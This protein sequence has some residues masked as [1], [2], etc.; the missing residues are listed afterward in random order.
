M[1]DQRVQNEQVEELRE[2]MRLLQGDRRAN[3]DLLETQKK[4]NAT[5][6][7]VLRDDNK[8]LRARVAHLKRT[9]GDEG[10]EAQI[11][12]MKKDIVH[13]RKQYD[14][15]KG[16]STSSNSKLE[17]LKDEVRACELE[18]RRPTDEDTP[19]TRSIRVLE[20]R[21]DKAM[22]KYNEATSIRKTY[23]QI[24]H[25]LKEERVGF[26]NQLSA[27]E[28]TLAAKQR[29]YEEL[30]LLSGDANHAREIAQIELDR[31][32]SGYEEERY[33]RENELRE[34]HQLVQM[35]RQMAERAEK[36]RLER[37]KIVQD[38]AKGLDTEGEQNM[39]AR[40]MEQGEE[41]KAANEA[42][43]K[44]DI[45][46][47]A[48]RKIKEATGVS[49]VNEVIQKIT[50][51]EGT[52]EN[53]LS[54]TKENAQRMDKLTNEATS[55]KARLDTLKFSGGGGGHRRK[56]VDDQEDQLVTSN[57]RLHR[58]TSKFERLNLVL[59]SSKAGIQHISSKLESIA[60]DFP[61]LKNVN[62]SELV[63]VLQIITRSSE[64]M[65]NRVKAHNIELG[66]LNST[67]SSS[68][69]GSV[70]SL[71]ASSDSSADL[72]DDEKILSK[73][74]PFN[75]R[76]TLPSGDEWEMMHTPGDGENGEGGEADEE[77]LT[78]AKVK[79]ASGQIVLSHSGKKRRKK[80]TAQ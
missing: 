53:L 17:I 1:N 63:E 18:S 49:D 38:N 9:E 11:V 57:A 52:T 2:R 79:E 28:R 50:S 26:D 65:M 25:R 77:E 30:L 70:P 15:L 69:D 32:R 80:K 36:R 71:A 34:R 76:V 60:D 27:L 5:E 13:L 12:S 44:I 31:V 21:L 78:R 46:E 42:R 67:T 73:S 51:Q 58:C 74:R 3:V 22:I 43:N 75:Q 37:E 45:F 40:V 55:T 48:F 47:N 19:L 72:F 20:N 23:E 66:V 62:S 41:A 35:R 7:Q 56:L 61:M 39:M 54:L 59:T 24:V 68:L 6:V 8:G 4:M 33:R 10:A 29:D 16:V 64:N 14:E